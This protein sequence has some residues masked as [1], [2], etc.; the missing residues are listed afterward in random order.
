MKSVRGHGGTQH[1]DKEFCGRD[2]NA[3][4]K[5]LMSIEILDFFDVLKCWGGLDLTPG[6]HIFHNSFA[7]IAF[8]V[9]VLNIFFNGKIFC[10]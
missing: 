2:I 5:Q 6:I 9:C 4:N 8:F 1:A 7:P 10:A 3:C